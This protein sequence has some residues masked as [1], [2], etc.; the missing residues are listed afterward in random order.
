MTL[1]LLNPDQERRLGTHLSVLATDLAA[2]AEAPELAAP[3]AAGLGN[4]LAATRAAADEVCRALG[5][6]ATRTPTFKHRVAAFASVWAARVDD[7]RPDGLRSYGPV[8]PA[9]ASELNALL[10][11]VRVSLDRVADAAAALP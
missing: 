1:K 10:L 9:L 3:T 7:L 11:N 6:P 4:A 2:L 8:H 5:I